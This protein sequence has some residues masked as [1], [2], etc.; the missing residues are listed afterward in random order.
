MK[1]L[2][3]RR[4]A[5]L[6]EIWRRNGHPP[7]YSELMRAVGLHSENPIFKHLQVLKRHGYVKTTP[8][9]CRTL[10]LTDKGLLAAQGYE[11]IYTCD[12]NGIHEVG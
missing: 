9:Q 7:R 8:G 2:S 11:F 1:V 10:T 6:R 5:I 3:P 4:K 12:Q